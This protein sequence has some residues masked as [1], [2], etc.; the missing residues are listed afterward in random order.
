VKYAWIR[1]HRDSFPVAVL[2]QVLEVSTSGYYAWLDREPSP[3]AQRQQRIQTA[4]QQVH[5]ES[6]SIYG[7]YK[8]ARQLAQRPDLDS[9]CSNTVAKAMR[10]LGLKS[11]IPRTLT[12]T[13]TQ[14]DPTK[15]PA[16]TASLRTS[17]P[18]RRTASG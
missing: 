4:V 17:P 6:H 16:P 15:Q 18:R 11:R 9:A 5:A 1:E 10:E 13:T 2:C 12:P 3:R 7:S 14:T 8:V